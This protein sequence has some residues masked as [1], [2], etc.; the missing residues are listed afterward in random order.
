MAERLG[1]EPRTRITPSDRLAICS[2][3]IIGPFLN[4]AEV[5]GFE[6]TAPFGTSVFKTAAL[7]HAQ[8]YFRDWCD[9]KD[10]NLPPQRS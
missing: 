1:L 3:T 8:P 2:N 10:S 9:R 6:P 5:V 4:L 7:N